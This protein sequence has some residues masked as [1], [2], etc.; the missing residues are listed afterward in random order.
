MNDTFDVNQDGDINVGDLNKNHTIVYKAFAYI[1]N[2][3]G[4]GNLTDVIVSQ[5]PVYFTIYNDATIAPGRY[6]PNGN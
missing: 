4:T 5:Q 1:G 2:G 3:D 6:M